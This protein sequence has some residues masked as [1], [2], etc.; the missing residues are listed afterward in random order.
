[1]KSK[2]LSLQTIVKE[3]GFL[4]KTV[5]IQWNAWKK[6]KTNKKDLLLLT[7][8]LIEKIPDLCDAKEHYQSLIRKKNTNSVK[9]W[10]ISTY[11]S[12]TFE[13]PDTVDLKLLQSIQKLHINY[14]RL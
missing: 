3:L 13:N 12:K 7:N 14:P 6:K 5:F 8:K 1:M 4:K 9:Q 2:T 10:K 11:Q